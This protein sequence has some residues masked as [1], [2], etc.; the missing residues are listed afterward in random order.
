MVDF[1]LIG[2]GLI[3]TV[4]AQNIQRHRKARLRYVVDVRADAARELAER[5]GGSATSDAQAALD[6]P[7]VEAVII[8]SSTDTHASLVNAAAAA[9]KAI[10]CEKPIAVDLAEARACLAEVA[11]AG[12]IAATGFNR[13][14]D[15]NHR[16]LF[17]GVRAGRVGRLEMLHLTSRSEAPPPAEVARRSGG[18]FR[19]KGSHFFDLARWIADEP[20][21]EVFAAGA[22]L[23][24]AEPARAGDVDTAMVTIRFASGL[25]GHCDF[26]RRTAYGYDER[27][28]A[29]GSAGMLESQ[30]ERFRGVAYYKDDKI[31]ADG[32]IQTWLE[33]AEGTYMAELDDFL[34]ALDG[35][36]PPLASL[37][38]GVEAQLIAEAA[39]VSARDKRLVRIDEFGSS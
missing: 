37:Q 31:V 23:I 36:R 8:A 30:R 4:H 12:V 25:L 15:R 34:A 17:D 11:A 32:L 22:N 20:V 16:A 6:D 39:F 2:A 19:D 24:D 21:V 7:A 9:G 26:S 38:D 5:H 3:G 27:I 10:L 1:A 33:R 29:F 13:R 28:E 14:F 18:L 35:K